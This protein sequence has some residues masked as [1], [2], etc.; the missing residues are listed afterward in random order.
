MNCIIKTEII[1]F[2]RKG[3]LNMYES[4]KKFFFTSAQR[5]IK[6][7]V[8]Q[9]NEKRRILRQSGKMQYK[10]LKLLKPTHIYPNK[11]K[12]IKDIL[13]G[14]GENI[15]HFLSPSIATAILEN[16]KLIPERHTNSADSELQKKMRMENLEFVNMSELY[17]GNDEYLLSQEGQF[18]FFFYLFND[19]L[20]SPDYGEKIEQYLIDYIP[21]ATHSAYETGLKKNKDLIYYTNY[22]FDENVDVFAEAVYYFCKIGY[23]E[24]LMEKFVELIHTKFEYE[25]KDSDGRYIKKETDTGFSVFEKIFDQFVKENVLPLIEETDQSSSL[26][27]RVHDIL[28]ADLL[29]MNSRLLYLDMSISP[30]AHDYHL[31][32][33]EEHEMDVMQNLVDASGKYVDELHNVQIQMYGDIEFEYFNSEVF[34]LRQR[35]KYFSMKRFK[36]LMSE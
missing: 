23:L 27:K 9:I 33:G 4:I 24:E 34:L 5:R 11:P 15:G 31:T 35:E 8:E 3:S 14:G 18:S 26:G 36:S 29:H 25:S 7:R 22:S 6:N 10:N 1:R 28:V 32:I 20:Q 21:F 30:E 16:I 17:W 19:L 12:L 13:N 2:F